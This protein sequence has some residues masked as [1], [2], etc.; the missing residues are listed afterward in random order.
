MVLANAA[1]AWVCGVMRFDV[2]CWV[3]L[4]FASTVEGMLT[5]PSDTDLVGLFYSGIE[6]MRLYHAQKSTVSTQV[7]HVNH[8]TI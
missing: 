8:L 2:A 1:C 6:M 4:D 3:C 5:G 7:A